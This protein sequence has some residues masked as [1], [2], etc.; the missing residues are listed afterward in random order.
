M[1]W[2]IQ[3][4]VELK[5]KVEEIQSAQVAKGMS[6]LISSHCNITEHMGSLVLV[7]VNEEQMAGDSVS[8]AIICEK[9]KQFFE[10][11]GG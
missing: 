1:V 10:E 2:I 6:R 7:C 3:R 9:A 4:S 8:E 5:K 11:L